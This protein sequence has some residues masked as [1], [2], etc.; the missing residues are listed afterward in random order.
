LVPSN[1]HTMSEEKVEKAEQE[2]LSPEQLEENRKKV[3]EYYKRQS[4]LLEHQARY[5]GLLAEIEVH[6]AKRM[7][8]IIRQA[9][10]SAAPDDK[11]PQDTATDRPEASPQEVAP[12]GEK[13]PRVLKKVD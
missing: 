8:M 3:I 11:D 12:E 9:Q 7:E 5:E 2:K 10:M 6:R 1:Q 13:K 4:E